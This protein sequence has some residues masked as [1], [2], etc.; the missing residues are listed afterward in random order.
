MENWWRNGSFRTYIY[1]TDT[2]LRKALRN[3]KNTSASIERIRWFKILIHE[4]DHSIENVQNFVWQLDWGQSMD[5]HN[6]NMRAYTKYRVVWTFVTLTF[7][8]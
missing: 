1:A 2:P 4:Q 3:K 8:S 5:G 6:A 7:I